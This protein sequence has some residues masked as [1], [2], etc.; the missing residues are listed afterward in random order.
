MIYGSK[1]ESTDSQNCRVLLFSVPRKIPNTGQ[2][3]LVADSSRFRGYVDF[4][5]MHYR[6]P[7]HEPVVYFLT[8]RLHFTP[9]CTPAIKIGITNNL[10]RRMKA[11]A[12][13]RK[14]EFEPLVLAVEWGSY[15]TREARLHSRFNNSRLA[16]EWFWP[17]DELIDLVNANWAWGREN[18]EHPQITHYGWDDQWEVDERREVDCMSLSTLNS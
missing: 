13:P 11:Y 2:V 7:N 18:I 10:A 9:A 5:D 12:H 6:D 1:E 8:N 16:G 4:S 15:S 14:G 17:A 3:Y